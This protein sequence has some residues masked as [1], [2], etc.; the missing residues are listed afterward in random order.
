M[1]IS[2]EFF[3]LLYPKT[4]FCQHGAIVFSLGRVRRAFLLIFRA[5]SQ[6]FA[7]FFTEK[8]FFFSVFSLAFHSFPVP[9]ARVCFW[10]C[11]G[12]FFGIFGFTIAQIIAPFA[13][14][15]SVCERQFAENRSFP[16]LCFGGVSADRRPSHGGFGR[17]RTRFIEGFLNF[18]KHV[19]LYKKPA[20]PVSLPYC[21]LK[22]LL[23][24]Y[25]Y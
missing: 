1:V 22:V 11:R 14:S 20:R 5:F 9:L 8:I 7:G 16:L 24:K 6:S 13:A 12:S 19:L 4:E 23:Q 18:A 25:P 3:L 21:S 2:F 17:G 10:F 15:E